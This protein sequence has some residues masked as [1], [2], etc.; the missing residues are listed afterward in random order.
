MG[1]KNVPGRPKCA[2]VRTGTIPCVEPSDFDPDLCSFSDY[3]GVD[4]NA[5]HLRQVTQRTQCDTHELTSPRG[6]EGLGGYANPPHVAN[7]ALTYYDMVD[8]RC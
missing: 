3:V 4:M 2:L 7:C 8:D 1:T 6:S 5:M